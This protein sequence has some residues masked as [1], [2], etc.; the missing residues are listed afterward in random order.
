MSKCLLGK[1]EVGL[2]ALAP[3]FMQRGRRTQRHE[4]HAATHLYERGEKVMGYA[5]QTIKQT[6]GK[7]AYQIHACIEILKVGPIDGRIYRKYCTWIKV[8]M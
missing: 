5:D 7:A 4:A 8:L 6:K 2:T 3:I 1:R